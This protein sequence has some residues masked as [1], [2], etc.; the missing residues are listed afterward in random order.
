VEAQQEFHSLRYN[1]GS[2]RSTFLGFFILVNA[3]CQV[4]DCLGGFEFGHT[5]KRRKTTLLHILW[6]S[7]Y[8]ISWLFKCSSMGG[9]ERDGWLRR[10]LG[11]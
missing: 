9:F 8:I 7:D 11:G 10:G 3:L 2:E 4:E 5:E 1:K 6:R